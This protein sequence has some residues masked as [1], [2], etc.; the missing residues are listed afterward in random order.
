MSSEAAADCRPV[1]L[2]TELSSLDPS[3]RRVFVLHGNTFL[4]KHNKRDQLACLVSRFKAKR[5][6]QKRSNERLKHKV[7]IF[8]LHGDGSAEH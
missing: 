7:E 2:T 6:P 8:G 1:R 5:N 4:T 3:R